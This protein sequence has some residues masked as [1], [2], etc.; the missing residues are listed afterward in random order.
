MSKQIKNIPHPVSQTF[1]GQ[2]IEGID[3]ADY[4]KYISDPSTGY[5][6]GDVNINKWNDERAKKQSGFAKFGNSVGQGVGT[7][8]TAIGSTFGVLAGLPYAAIHEAI[9]PGDQ[10]TFDDVLANPIVKGFAD[11]DSYIKNEALPT[12]YTKQQQEDIFS[13]ATG[14]DVLNGVGFLLSAVVPSG[15]IGKVFGKL[16]TAVQASKL[17]KLTPILQDAV[18]AGTISI[19]EA[20]VATGLVNV[21]EKTGA[22]T[23][24]VVG[25][26]GESAME[27]NDSYN[28]IKSELFAKREEANNDIKRFGETTNKEY[29]SLTD[30]EIENRAKSQADNVFMGN[31][32]LAVSDVY[33]QA[34]W[35]GKNPLGKMI[36][37]ETTGLWKK[38]AESIGKK[39]LRYLGE[40]IQEAGEEGF[41]FILQ[42]GAKR[43]AANPN[44]KDFLTDKLDFAG[45]VSESTGDLFTTSQGIKSMLLGA[46]LGGGASAVFAGMNSKKQNQTLNALVENLNSNS[47]PKDAYTIAPDGKR[48]IKPEYEKV[49]HK[50]MIYEKLKQEAADKGDKEEYD[51]LEKQQFAEIVAA[52]HQ[53]GKL[54][55]YL[56]SLK[57]M[58]KMSPE[59]VSTIGWYDASDTSTITISSKKYRSITLYYYYYYDYK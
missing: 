15:A 4:D 32:L 50:F 6:M 7:F 49:A 30:E 11:I 13:A 35:F 23:G 58:G 12:Y 52:K 57:A 18:K 16:G 39:S 43:A 31:M 2:V 37:Q 22:L 44:S 8:G 41:Q 10:D 5:V 53:A 42:E 1:P 40:A 17:G 55:E 59:E 26:L 20:G 54:N 9:T 14:T 51:L 21:I 56:D 29:L 47:D 19:E 3:L 38:T 25:R 46:V 34:R 33:Q 45:H 27:R 28:Q 24:A 36:E 48:V